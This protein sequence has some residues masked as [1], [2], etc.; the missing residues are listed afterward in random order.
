ME[1]QWF[2]IH[3]FIGV[4]YFQRKINNN[5]QSSLGRGRQFSV[6]V[7]RIRIGRLYVVFEIFFL[8]LKKSTR[9]FEDRNLDKSLQFNK[10][11][12]GGQTLGETDCHYIL[13]TNC[14]LQCFAGLLNIYNYYV[15]KY[16]LKTMST[17]ET[18]CK[19][20]R[21]IYCNYIYF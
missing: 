8:L 1:S 20:C 21:L 17:Y 18:N 13:D 10:M 2:L 15:P 11:K 12:K 6:S 19:E 7:W 5:Y 9:L 14:F 3:D 16:T 4:Q